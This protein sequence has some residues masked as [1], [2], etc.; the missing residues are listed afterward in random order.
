[1]LARLDTA[2]A[3]AP[4]EVKAPLEAVA[5]ELRPI[6]TDFV[7]VRTAVAEA[8]AGKEAAAAAPAQGNA[9][10]YFFATTTISRVGVLVVLLFLVSFLVNLYRY[11]MRLAAYYDARADALALFQ[12]TD[13]G[14]PELI[15]ALSPDGM[16]FGKMPRSPTDHAVELAKAM[17]EVRKVT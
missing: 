3:S 10:L 14:L 8:R 12:L 1:M 6:A 17:L 2:A 7:R 15:L 16:D 11:N 13:L 9:A 4:P 5:A